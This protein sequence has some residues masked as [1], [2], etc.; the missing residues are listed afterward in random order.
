MRAR[1][2][3]MF[4]VTIFMGSLRNVRA[5]DVRRGRSYCLPGPLERPSI[6]YP[7]AGP[8]CPSVSRWTSVGGAVKANAVGFGRGVESF[9]AGNV[10][11]DGAGGHAVG[12]QQSHIAGHDEG[13][14]G[15]VVSGHAGSCR[16]RRAR[17]PASHRDRARPT[18]RPAE[19]RRW[20]PHAHM[21]KLVPQPQEATAFGFLIWNDWPIRSSTKSITE[22]PI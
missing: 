16:A 1:T 17:R 3:L 10:E 18:A 9:E 8:N 19:P 4:Q 5:E 12:E 7:A 21:E 14:A 20:Q 22:P 2:P 13:D 15:R 11:I 6:R